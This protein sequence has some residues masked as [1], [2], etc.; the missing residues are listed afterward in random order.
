M[1]FWICKRFSGWNVR[2][3]SEDCSR[4]PTLAAPS[5]CLSTQQTCLWSITMSM[6]FCKCGFC[7]LFICKIFIHFNFG[8]HKE[9]T[10]LVLF[11]FFLFPLIIR[12]SFYLAILLYLSQNYCIYIVNTKNGCT[13]NYAK[14]NVKIDV[15]QLWKIYSDIKFNKMKQN[16]VSKKCLNLSTRSLI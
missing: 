15:C 9:Q 10:L 1:L 12:N 3:R 11:S 4:V 16:L 8:I 13:Q 7:H 2:G 14:I 5:L 6:K